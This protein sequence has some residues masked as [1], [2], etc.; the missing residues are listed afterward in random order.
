MEP[1]IA[2]RRL[3]VAASLGLFLANLAG[4]WFLIRDPLRGLPDVGDPFDLKAF[5]TREVSESQNAFPL[6]ESA[7][8]SYAQNDRARRREILEKWG[9][10]Q[11]PVLGPL[12]WSAVSPGA[13]AWLDGN[14]AALDLWKSATALPAFQ[15]HRLRRI[16][17]DAALFVEGSFHTFARLALLD[18][19]RRETEG[20]MAGALEDY[21]ALFRSSRHIGQNNGRM[22]RQAGVRLHQAA[23][24][25]LIRWAADP[26]TDASLLR[27]ALANATDDDSLTVPVSVTYQIE[28]LIYLA[29]LDDGDAVA[30]RMRHDLRYWREGPPLRRPN[31]AST[32]GYERLP[33]PERSAEWVKRLST[34]I[35][36]STACE[37]DRS[38]RILRLLI[39]NRLAHADDGPDRPATIAVSTPMLYE[40]TSTHPAAARALEP[41]ELAGWYATSDL[42]RFDPQSFDGT[43]EAALARERALQRH[44]LDV[45]AVEV[46][47][48]GD[49]NRASGP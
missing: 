26:R 29:L 5:C 40:T 7:Q 34:E 24:E 22:L 12:D 10:W 31:V 19:A 11:E 14:R 25:A 27:R 16:K 48:R 30:R 17:L 3:I 38:R 4:W 2:H 21:R 33:L 9:K 6:Y 49:Q 13:R 1:M 42:A 20:D 47:K 39:A 37:P 44:L 18:A 43:F 41:G 32:Q 23:S 8:R 35:G 45:L 15:S 36:W 46:A 28:Y